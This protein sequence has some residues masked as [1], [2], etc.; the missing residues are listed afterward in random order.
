MQSKPRQTGAP[1][2][3]PTLSGCMPMKLG[4]GLGEEH[5]LPSF[6][7]SDLTLNSML[8][9]RA[10]S[11]FTPHLSHFNCHNHFTLAFTTDPCY[12]TSPAHLTNSVPPALIPHALPN[13]FL[14]VHLILLPTPDFISSQTHF[15]LSLHPSSL[16]PHM[17]FH[18][19]LILKSHTLD[20]SFCHIQLL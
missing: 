17:R 19:H 10:L 13:L 16:R 9:P 6:P 2:F 12:P 14:H 5:N 15:T 8:S 11:F 1:S 3:Q 18:T 7:T 20:P 4:C